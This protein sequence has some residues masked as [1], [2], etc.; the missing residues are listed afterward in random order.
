M[1]DRVNAKKRWLAYLG[2]AVC[3]GVA[4]FATD[5]SFSWT[6]SSDNSAGKCGY[7][8]NSAGHSVP[9]PCGNWHN[10]GTR[11]S[12]ATAQCQDGTWSYSEHPNAPGTCSRHG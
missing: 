5:P 2:I 9:R 11:P 4:V 10:D 1:G 12:G 3:A 6:G 8:T 7:Y